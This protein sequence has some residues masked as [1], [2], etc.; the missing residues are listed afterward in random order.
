MFINISDKKQQLISVFGA[1]KPDQARSKED[2]GSQVCV[3]VSEQNLNGKF[4]FNFS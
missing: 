4:H 1:C 3:C 2:L